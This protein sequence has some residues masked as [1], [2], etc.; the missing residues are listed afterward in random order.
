MTNE[1]LTLAIEMGRA[2]LKC[3]AEVARV[4][5]TITRICAAYGCGDINVFTITSS[6]IVTVQSPEGK[7]ITQTRRVTA[8][9]LNLTKIDRLNALSRR[10]C[11]EKTAIASVLPEVDRILKEPVYGFGMLCFASA[12]ASASFTAFFGGN[13]QDILVS[14]VVGL[15]MRCCM[16]LLEK[17]GSNHLFTNYVVAFISGAL[18]ICSVRLGL[19][20]DYEK[21]I[22]GNIM[23]LISGVAFFNSLRD[24]IT[25]D[26][27]AG[28]LRLCEAV[29]L[30]VLIAAGT[31][32][33][34]FMMGVGV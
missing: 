25:G 30:A 12:G 31:V 20:A 3:G 7:M 2:M 23:L 4:E 26:M 16:T 21:I 24:I 6:I 22:I 32:T 11:S 1:V 15:V 29:V 19:G 9:S 27:M 8:S 14:A 13:W 17:A 34:M 28:I 18:A 10:I 33:A 5:D